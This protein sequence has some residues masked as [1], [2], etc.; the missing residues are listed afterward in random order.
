MRLAY[1]ELG[2]GTPIVCLPPFSLDRS[3]M[4]AAMEPVLARRAGL[5]RIYVDL[6]G[7]GESPAGEPTSE[8]VADAV[9]SFIDAHLGG[10]P[11]LLAGWSYG[12]YIAAAL[13]RRKPARIA[14]LLQI[15]AGAK[16]RPEDRDLPPAPAEP[17]PRGWL[18]EVAEDLKAHLA[19]AIGNRTAPTAARVAGVMAASR[20]GDEEYR[21]R[22]QAGGYQLADE[23]RAAS[24]PGPTCV[25]TGRQD[26]VV[27]F[28]D[29]FRALPAYPAASFAV[30]AEAGHY[31]PL[32]QPEAFRKVTE[33]WLDQCAQLTRATR[34]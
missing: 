8:Y 22:L 7:H 6:P 23:G 3:V 12:G 34:L 24:Y 16:T 30:V 25:I 32:E 29:Q 2:Q 13:A 18:D 15:C 5:R 11:R 10:A 26:R 28:A 33:P 4:A 27:G 20:P 1:D 31:L 14:G 19:T 21:R 17:A 9:S